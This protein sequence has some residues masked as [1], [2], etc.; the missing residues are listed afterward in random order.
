MFDCFDLEYCLCLSLTLGL[1]PSLSKERFLCG[2]YLD[3]LSLWVEKSSGWFSSRACCAATCCCC[4][5]RAMNAMNWFGS[6]PKA[7]SAK[8]SD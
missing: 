1:L 7:T 4:R 5:R 2:K 3:K 8:S 6:I